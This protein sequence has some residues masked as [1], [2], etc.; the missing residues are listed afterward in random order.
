MPR[1]RT[2]QEVQFLEYFRHIDKNARKRLTMHPKYY[3]FDT[4]VVN[5]IN[6]RSFFIPWNLPTTWVER[7]NVHGSRLKHPNWLL[8]KG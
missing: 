5:A 7:F 6:G 3:L 8:T 4:S 1:T 2:L